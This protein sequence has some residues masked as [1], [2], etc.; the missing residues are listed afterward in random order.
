MNAQI[1]IERQILAMHREIA[2]R[3]RTGDQTPLHKAQS[4]LLRWRQQFGGELPA[5]YRE[6]QQLLADPDQAWLSLLDAETETAVRLRSS[7][8]FAGVFSAAE[9]W[10]ILRHAA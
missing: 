10:K 1:K 8:P 3:L 2:R 4:N 9:R 6:W 7:S 5:P